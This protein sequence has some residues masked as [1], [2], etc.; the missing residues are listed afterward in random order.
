[1]EARVTLRPGQRGT[2]KL[3]ERFGDRLI[4]VRY[5]YDIER[6]RRVTTVELVV[7]EAPWEPSAGSQS[8]L[9]GVRVDYRESELRNR[10][11]AA[12]GQWGPEKKLWRLRSREARELGLERRIVR[13]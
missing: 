6:R 1:M 13:M 10:V 11:K 7:D 2:K 8:R 3:T 4:C 9:V 12:G 5:R